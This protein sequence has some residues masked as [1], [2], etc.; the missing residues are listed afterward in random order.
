MDRAG[1]VSQTRAAPKQGVDFAVDAEARWR[2]VLSARPI[3]GGSLQA[4][5][6]IVSPSTMRQ[7]ASRA[8]YEP[9]V[10]FD[11]LSSNAHV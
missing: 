4:I 2:V 11:T 5:P 6:L 9:I 1:E 8:C 3:T 7:A 10:P